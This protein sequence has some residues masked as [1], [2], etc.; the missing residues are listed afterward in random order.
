LPVNP[1][2]AAAVTKIIDS[3]QATPQNV[4]DRMSELMVTKKAD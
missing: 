4:I 2:R 3:V 1:L